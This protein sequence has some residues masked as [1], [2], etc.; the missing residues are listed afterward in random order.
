MGVVTDVMVHGPEGRLA[1]VLYRPLG[2]VPDVADDP[3]IVAWSDG[4]AP[5]VTALRAAIA[6]VNPALPL[7][8]IRTFAQVRADALS[9]RRF[10]RTMLSAYGVVSFGLAALGLYALV[11]YLV[12]RRSREFGIRLALGAS[13]ASLRRD[14][15]RNGALLAVAGTATGSVISFTAARILWSMIPGFGQIEAATILGVSVA[16]VTTAAAAA[17][18]PAL[19][20]TKVDPVV[21]LRY[22]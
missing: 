16:L 4:T 12:Q 6:R 22:E 10:A 21:A 5:P 7:F 20:A 17:W 19:T 11:A 13:P 2:Q 15:L 3:W 18:L 9:D 14:V 1:P 8:N